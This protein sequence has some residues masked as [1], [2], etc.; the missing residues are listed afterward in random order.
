MLSQSMSR[1]TQLLVSLLKLHGLATDVFSVV[2]WKTFFFLLLL[3]KRTYFSGLGTVCYGLGM[4]FIHNSFGNNT[5]N[6]RQQSCLQLFK[7]N[8]TPLLRQYNSG[9]RKFSWLLL[10]LKNRPHNCGGWKSSQKIK[11]SFSD[12]YLFFFF[13]PNSVFFFSVLPLLQYELLHMLH[14]ITIYCS[15]VYFCNHW[16]LFHLFAFWP[17]LIIERFNDQGISRLEAL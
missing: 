16:I 11:R 5:Y 2:Q 10:S 4:V 14:E 13:L 7:R 15:V 3:K 1:G 8:L 12:K 17:L 9:Q 6:I